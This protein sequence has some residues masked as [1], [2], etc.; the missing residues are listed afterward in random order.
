MKKSGELAE[1]VAD[2]IE[3][4]QY[5]FPTDKSSVPFVFDGEILV[6]SSIVENLWKGLVTNGFTL[7]DP[8]ITSIEPVTPADSTLF[9][10]SW[11]MDVFFNN[12][13]PPL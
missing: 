2:S 7:K 1:Q 13:I 6:T 4:G 5:Q 8:V 3:I 10:D 11:E 12:I 9:R